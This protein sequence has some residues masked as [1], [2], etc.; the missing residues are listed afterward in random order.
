MENS[1]LLSAIVALGLFGCLGLPSKHCEH[2]EAYHMEIRTA[3]E[4]QQ[5][6]PKVL[7]TPFNFV[8]NTSGNFF[9]NA[10][11]GAYR[12]TGN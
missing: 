1:N 5:K 9:I 10:E 11:P 4:T 8:V 7:S 6:M 12:I 3:G 2:A